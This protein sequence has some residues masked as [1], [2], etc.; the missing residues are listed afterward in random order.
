MIS[1]VIINPIASRN[2]IM[3]ED[4]YSFD[5]NPPYIVDKL[6]E[7][8]TRTTADQ[9]VINVVTPQKSDIRQYFLESTSE[10]SAL[11]LSYVKVPEPMANLTPLQNM[12][13]KAHFV[14]KN[15]EFKRNDWTRTPSPITNTIMTTYMHQCLEHNA[16]HQAKLRG[17]QRVKANLAQKRKLEKRWKYSHEHF[18]HPN[19]WNKVWAAHYATLHP[20]N[21]TPWLPKTKIPDTRKP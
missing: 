18:K 15:A 21:K 14:S 8:P 2:T 13:M 17:Q 9:P 12:K 3:T 5:K 1:T 6:P 4:S 16:M 10:S 19:P 7:S 20:L 11:S